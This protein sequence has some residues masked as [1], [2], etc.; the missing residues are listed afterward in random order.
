MMILIKL[1]CRTN[2]KRKIKRKTLEERK[3]EEKQHKTEELKRL[4]NL[5]KK[6]IFENLQKIKE[7]TGNESTWNFFFLLSFF[8]D[9]FF[10]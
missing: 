2:E 3:K 10:F 5:K 4:K 9:Y 6:E 7:I 8:L 1:I